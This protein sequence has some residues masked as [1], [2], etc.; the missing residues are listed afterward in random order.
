AAA[1]VYAYG[2]RTAAGDIR[3][4]GAGE[5]GRGYG[6]VGRVDAGNALAEGDGEVDRGCSRRIGAGLDDRLHRWGGLVDRIDVAG[7]EARRQRVACRIIDGC[8]GAVDVKAD[9]SVATAGAHGHGIR[10][11]AGDAGDTGA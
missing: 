7:G 10:T 5:G 2:E 3:D 9:R 6:E 4:R 1:G 11:A 8:G